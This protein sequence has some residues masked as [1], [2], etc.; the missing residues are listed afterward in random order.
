MYDPTRTYRMLVLEL[1]G[2]LLD[3]GGHLPQRDVD[4]IHA[5]LARG[6]YVVLSSTRV[7]WEIMDFITPQTLGCLP[8]AI[9]SYGTE[10]YDFRPSPVRPRHYL[11]STMVR[12]VLEVTTGRDVII[13]AVKRSVFNGSSADLEPARMARFHLDSKQRVFNYIVSRDEDL[14]QFLAKNLDEIERLVV[15][16][17]SFEE[18]QDSYQRLSEWPLSLAY[19][20]ATGLQVMPFGV[21]KARGIGN[22]CWDLGISMDDVMAIASSNYDEDTCKSVGCA[23]AMGNAPQSVQDWCDLIVADNDRDGAGDAIE[24]YFLASEPV[25]PAVGV[26]DAPPTAAADEI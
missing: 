24:R 5:A 15:Y 6:Q 26:S 9:L 17:T 19:H 22:I 10:V 13:H 16:H 18:C 1:D 2:V 25:G 3:A 14:R 11:P 20:R 7:M 4:L 21:S 8:Y 12:K 23:V